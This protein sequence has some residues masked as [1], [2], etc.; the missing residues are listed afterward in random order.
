MLQGQKLRIVSWKVFKNGSMS[1]EEE[2]ED[3]VFLLFYA[4]LQQCGLILSAFLFL[5]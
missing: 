4:S 2:F 5:L 1:E 3:V